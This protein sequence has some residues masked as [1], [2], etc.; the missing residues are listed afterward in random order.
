MQLRHLALVAASTLS[1]IFPPT[2]QAADAAVRAVGK[3]TEVW[4]KDERYAAFHKEL[5]EK[6]KDTPGLEVFMRDE[7]W[8]SVLV[9]PSMLMPVV[10]KARVRPGD[11]L[12]LEDVVEL[13]VVENT[14]AGSYAST[15]TVV[16]VV[17]RKSATAEF[18]DC[19]SKNTLGMWAADGSV[20][21]PKRN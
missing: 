5:A 12:A 8:V 20:V 15:S 7:Q 9:S 11:Q 16:T 10:I 6:F 17:C 21:T 19:S 1:L 18:G 4:A 2:V 3:V 13:S 14:S